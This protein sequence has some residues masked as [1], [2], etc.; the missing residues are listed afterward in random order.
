MSELEQ[1]I[2][3]LEKAFTIEVQVKKPIVVGQDNCVGRRQLIELTEGI[4]KGRVNGKVLPGGVDSQIIRPDGLCELEARYGVVLEDG[5]SFYIENKGI[6]RVEPEYAAKAAAGEIIDPQYV[7]FA[8]VPQFEI[9]SEKLKWLKENIFIC[10][11]VRL[12]E[13]VLLNYY[14]VK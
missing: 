9:Y 14:M 7:Y 5:E 11:A 4:V 10:Y 6:R 1:K 13:V 12:P 8:T 3:S 2:P